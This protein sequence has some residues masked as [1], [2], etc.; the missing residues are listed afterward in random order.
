V[1]TKFV[2]DT[3]Y[4]TFSRTS[5]HPYAYMVIIVGEDGKGSLVGCRTTIENARSTAT[6]VTK[7]C[8]TEYQGIIIE[9]A[10]G[11]EVR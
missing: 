9:I 6:S 5:D 1:K 10:T 4:G 2:V 3:K 7:N 11:K 8:C